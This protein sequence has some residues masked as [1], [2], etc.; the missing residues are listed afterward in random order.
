MVIIHITT[1]EV[2]DLFAEF[3]LFFLLFFVPAAE[4]TERIFRQLAAVINFQSGIQQ[5]THRFQA[6]DGINHRRKR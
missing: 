6:G 3:C 1:V 2:R 5:F 4:G